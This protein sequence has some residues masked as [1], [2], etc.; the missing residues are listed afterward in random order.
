GAVVGEAWWAGGGGPVSGAQPWERR[1]PPAH[2]THAARRSLGPRRVIRP[3]RSVGPL[4]DGRGPRPAEALSSSA[5]RTRRASW[6][7]TA[8]TSPGGGAA[9]PGPPDPPPP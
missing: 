8:L 1:R 9:P 5:Q 7:G 6:R 3:R 2:S 4:W